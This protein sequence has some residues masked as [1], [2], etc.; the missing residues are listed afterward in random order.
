[1]C[2]S[3]VFMPTNTFAGEK[4]KIRIVGS[5]TVFPFATAIAEEFGAL[6]AFPTPT[7]ESTGSGGGIKLFCGGIG[8]QHPDIVNASRAMK[9]SERE[10]CRKNGVTEISEVVIGYDGIVLASSKAGQKI[11]LTTEQIFLALAEKVPANK[12]GSGDLVANYYTSWDQIDASLPNIKIEVLG[13]PPTSGTRDA[14]VELVMHKG[15]E[16]FEG[17]A[18]MPKKQRKK[19]CGL[20]REDGAYIDAGENDN[21]IIQKLTNN[22][23]AYGLFGYSFLDRNLDKLDGNHVNGVEPTFENIAS[24]DYPLSR[25]LFFYVKRQH[26]GVVPGIQEYVAEFFSEKASGEE[27]YLEERGLIPLSGDKRDTALRN[28]QNEGILN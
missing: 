22:A 2:L 4:R 19:H 23:A 6:T 9:D 12:D 5:S 8:K 28:A 7:I 21:L 3:L 10:L 13:P 1:M 16:K 26:I 14:F 18:K 17:Y 20:I 15:C 24:G 27:G 11:D 25:P